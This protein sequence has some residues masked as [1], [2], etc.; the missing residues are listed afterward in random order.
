M[1]SEILILYVHFVS[2]IILIAAV[3]GQAFLL[4]G[5]LSRREVARLSCLDTY[6]H[7]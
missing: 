3:L 2:L 5:E 7:R 6:Q 4:R 1:Y